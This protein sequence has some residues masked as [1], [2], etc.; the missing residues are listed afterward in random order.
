MAR[1]RTVKPELRTS[2]VVASWPIPARY[3]WVLL[4]GY[5]DDH[6]RGLDDTRLI[7]AD[8]F[9]L[10]RSVTEKTLDGWL[11]LWSTPTTDVRQAPLC[12]YEVAGQR[13][14]HAVN[15]REH[16]RVNRPS[17]SRLPA[18]P[19]HE[20]SVRPHGRLTEDSVNPHGSL[21]DDSLRA[22][23]ARVRSRGAGEQGSRDTTTSGPPAAPGE[24]DPAPPDTAQ[25]L[26]AD[27]LDHC[28]Q[29][30]P[31]RVVS[32]V[33]RELRTLLDD[34]IDPATLRRGLATWHARRLHPS[35]L[36]SVVNETIQGPPPTR[37]RAVAD[38]PDPHYWRPHVD[39]DDDGLGPLDATPDPNRGPA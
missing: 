32:H 1:I 31:S 10:D 28:T 19:L 27:W 20:S 18:C 8:L 24:P 25:A 6:G 37:L 3:G 35:T 39:P 11:A 5:L 38:D 22:H 7:K 16:Q 15:W 33:G 14:I 4:W 21:S 13:Y 30:P 36:A 2:L 12:R 34:G 26:V 23:S 29:R 9:P 17:P